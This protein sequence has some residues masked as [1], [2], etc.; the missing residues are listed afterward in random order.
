MAG[1]YKIHGYGQDIVDDGLVVVEGVHEVTSQS[2]A[3]CDLL[4]QPYVA[5]QLVAFNFMRLDTPPAPWFRHAV[6]LGHIPVEREDKLGPLVR[7]CI[8]IPFV[9][10][11]HLMLVYCAPMDTAAVRFSL[12][13][14]E[15]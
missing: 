12:L 5:I 7:V 14:F 10:V 9:G 1:S 13:V 4:Q 6:G 2:R 8:Q 11:E 3:V 15:I